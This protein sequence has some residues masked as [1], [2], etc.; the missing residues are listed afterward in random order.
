MYTHYLQS[1]SAN[2]YQQ[3]FPK[4]AHTLY[5]TTVPASLLYITACLK[6]EYFLLRVRF[7]KIN[8]TTDKLARPV[9]K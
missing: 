2:G 4:A 3:Q 8:S 7:Q 1:G 5:G 9:E 6:D